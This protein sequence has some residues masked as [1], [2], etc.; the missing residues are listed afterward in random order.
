MVLPLTH[1]QDQF[2][3]CTSIHLTP[4]FLISVCAS[5]HKIE[6]EVRY[7]GTAAVTLN[8]MVWVQAMCFSPDGT[9]TAQTQALRWGESITFYKDCQS[10]HFY[11][12]ALPKYDQQRKTASP[13]WGKGY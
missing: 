7:V 9:L 4:P 10:V 12:R 1:L 6:Y 3:K 13:F 11:Y 2:E 5:F 8:V